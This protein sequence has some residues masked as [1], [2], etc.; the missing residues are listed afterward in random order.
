MNSVLLITKSRNLSEEFGA[1]SSGSRNGS[2]P[3][4]LLPET[5]ST[6]LR[7]H[8]QRK[9]IRVFAIIA[10]GAVSGP[11]RGLFQ[12]AEQTKDMGV[13]FLL[14]LF[15]LRSFPT[16]P[17]I[18]EAERR[19]YRVAIL[20]QR[21]AYDFF[22]PILQGLKIIREGKMSILQSHGYKPSLLAW[23][24][25][26]LT[27]LPWIAFAHGYTNENRRIALYNRLDSWVLRR[28]D[29]VVV[30]SEATG[31]FVEAA[32][33]S[34]HAT[35]VISNAIDPS[36]YC[37]SADGS[38]FRMS[39]GAEAGDVLIGVI[40]R[41]SP[42]KGHRIFLE[43]FNEVAETCPKAKAVFIGDG[44][45]LPA[46]KAQSRTATFESRLTF[47][48][49]RSDMS[50]IYKALDLVVIPSLSEGLPNVLL[51]GM[52]FCKPVVATAVGGVPE[53]LRGDLATWMVPAGDAGA[54]A[55]AIIQACMDKDR[56]RQLGESGRQHVLQAFSPF[57][58]AAQ[59]VQL[60]RDLLDA[61][62]SECGLLP[63]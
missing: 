51:E 25:K 49:Y 60:Y 11:C 63:R 14:G 45:D 21:N 37:L 32:G 40:G 30:V 46:L 16:T 8:A 9:D 41:M 48:G 58:R 56:R 59:M 23:V 3:L 4:S 57:Q 10:S 24:L 47:A 15:L 62:G 31:R 6:R 29:R 50:P 44:Q 61:K 55:H 28:A 43:A 54:L 52:F 53:V 7:A 20:R 38:K 34:P 12:L 5:E 42:E 36:D 1:R 33:V 13:D 17:S 19:G 39:C 27:G 22:Q 26:K 18:D 35:R 2:S